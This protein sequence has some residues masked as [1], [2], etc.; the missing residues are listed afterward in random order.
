MRKA[1]II[2][3]V[4]VFAVISLFAG[5]ALAE[6]KF[7][8][9]PRL[10]AMEM[11]AMFSPVAEY[12]SKEVGEKVSLI[13]P[14]DFDSFKALIKENQVDFGF[15]N[16]LVYIEIRKNVSVD[17]FA[18]AVEKKAGTKFRGI[19]IARK[20]SGIN[21]IQDMKGKKL[22]FVD[23]S[24]VVYLTGMLMLSKTGFDVNKDFTIL[25]FAKKVDNVTLAVFN[26]AA[27]AGV[28]REDDL[29]KLKDKVDIDQ[30][31]IVAYTDY[32]PNW[33]V[34]TTPHAGK[35]AAAKIKAALLKLKPNGTEFEK[36]LD[37]AKLKG[38]S[39][40]SDKDYDSLRQAAKLVGEL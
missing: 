22:V 12:L 20:D 31:K 27:D 2:G 18:V 30:L 17:P 29:D 37:A 16:S 1:G 23:K 3:L 9:L 26:K 32:S 13:I 40:V 19:F 6:I 7:A 15:S 8:I 14:K 10:S 33:P 34:F 4:A 21:S 35:D 24:S 5:R 38:F 39:T 28:I 36:I 25:P 11:H